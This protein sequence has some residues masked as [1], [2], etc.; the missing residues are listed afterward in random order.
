MPLQPTAAAAYTLGSRTRRLRR[1]CRCRYAHAQGPARLVDM[2]HPHAGKTRPVA[3]H[4]MLERSLSLVYHPQPVCLSSILIYRTR[5]E[6]LTASRWALVES[7]RRPC[8]WVYGR[9]GPSRTKSCSRMPP[10]HACAVRASGA[11]SNRLGKRKTHSR[12]NWDADTDAFSS[13]FFTA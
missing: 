3:H 11:R 13:F 10:T 2:L 9:R 5:D 1:R 8:Q 4:S 7:E 12:T 6:V